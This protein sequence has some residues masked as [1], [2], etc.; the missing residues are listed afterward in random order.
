MLDIKD[1]FCNYLYVDALD[2]KAWVQR[3][4]TTVVQTE[5]LFDLF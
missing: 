1:T 4:S 2:E 3:K 5:E